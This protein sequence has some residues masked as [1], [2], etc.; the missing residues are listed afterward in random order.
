MCQLKYISEI[1]KENSW[2]NNFIQRQFKKLSKVKTNIIS[3]K[4]KFMLIFEIKNNNINWAGFEK[5][6]IHQGDW[7]KIRSKKEIQR[8]LNDRNEYRG[9]AFMREM[10]KHCGKTYRV[11]KFVDYFFDEARQKM[12]KS[13]DTV[14]LDGAVCSGKQRLHLVNCDRNCFFFWKIVWLEKVES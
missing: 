8:T 5:P 13:R 3:I 1:K 4:N 11:L 12:V 10:Y 2:I 7:V 9:C 14:I 6:N